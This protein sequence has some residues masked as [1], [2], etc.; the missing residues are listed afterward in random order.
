MSAGRQIVKQLDHWVVRADNPQFLFQ[1]LSETLQLPVAMAF[2]NAIKALV[3]K[4]SSLKEAQ[5]FLAEKGMLG[6]LKSGEIGVAPDKI[7]GLDVRLA[8]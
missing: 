5:T 7:Y 2:E 4:V 8:E 6:V 3:L 1:L